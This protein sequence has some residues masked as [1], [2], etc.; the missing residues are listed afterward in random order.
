MPGRNGKIHRLKPIFVHLPKHVIMVQQNAISWFEIPTNDIERATAFYEA[1]FSVQFIP[2]DF[3]NIKM[4]MFPVE[5]PESGVG[6]ALVQSDGYHVPS[7]SLGPLIYLNANP[8]VQ[9]VLNKVEAAG[10]KVLVP[11]T[12]ISPEYGYMGVFLDTEGNRIALH[13]VPQG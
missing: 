13:S 3:P 9:Q 1:V 2:L 8:D 6:G 5:N 4:R 12:Q 7:D 10:G 11:K